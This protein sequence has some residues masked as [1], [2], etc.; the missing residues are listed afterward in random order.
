[1]RLAS[2]L[3]VAGKRVLVRSDLNVPVKDGVVGDDGQRA[4]VE[5]LAQQRHAGADAAVV[6]DGPVLHRHVEVAADEDPLARDVEVGREAHRVQRS[7]PTSA[8]RSTRRF[9]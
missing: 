2:D 8:M 5:Q 1:M 6:P 4:A 3:D 9:E 7:L